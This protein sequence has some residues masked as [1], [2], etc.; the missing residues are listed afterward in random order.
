[1]KNLKWAALTGFLIIVLAQCEYNKS[2][3]YEGPK[4]PRIEAGDLV[5]HKLTEDT[6]IVTRRDGRHYLRLRDKNYKTLR[7]PKKELNLVR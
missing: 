6:L 1:M 4:E 3:D 2:N 5:I 7:L